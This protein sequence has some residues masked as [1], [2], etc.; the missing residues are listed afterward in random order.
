MIPRSE[1][2]FKPYHIEEIKSISVNGAQDR[3]IYITA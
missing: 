3:V 1:F 2:D